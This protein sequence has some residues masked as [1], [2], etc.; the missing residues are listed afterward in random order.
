MSFDKTLVAK[1]LREPLPGVLAQARYHGALAK[2]HAAPLAE[3]KWS[4]SDTEALVV[5]TDA[6]DTAKAQQLDERAGAHGDTRDQAGAVSSAKTLIQKLRL[7]LPLVLADHA[8]ALG[9][10]NKKVFAVPGGELGRSPG[11]VSAYLNQ[12]A[13]AL[14]KLDPFFA[15]Y[16]D[17]QKLSELAR[18]AKLKLDQTSATQDLS[19]A[20]LP[21]EALALQEQKG[22]LLKLIDRLNALGK[23]RFHGD[24]ATSGKFNRDLLLAARKSRPEPKPTPPA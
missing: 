4:A 5:A 15:G 24:A 14:T 3:K 20:N 13:P 1:G 2:L 16:F 22:K 12:I 19:E 10:I 11:T 9:D 21:D 23:L 7:V 18:A 8:D 17:D 6:V